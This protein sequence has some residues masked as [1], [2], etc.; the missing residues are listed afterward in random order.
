MI[1]GRLLFSFILLM[2]TLCAQASAFHWLTTGPFRNQ[3]QEFAFAHMMV[4]PS[5]N[6]WEAGTIQISLSRNLQPDFELSQVANEFEQAYRD[7]TWKKWQSKHAYYLQAEIQKENRIALIKLVKIQNNKLLMISSLIRPIFWQEAKMQVLHLASTLENEFVGKESANVEHW[8]HKVSETLIPQAQAQNFPN[9]PG[10]P[11]GSLP[12]LGPLMDGL[13]QMNNQI[14]DFN[15]SLSDINNNWSETNKIM[16]A[17]LSK[18]FDTK[19]MAMHGAVVGAATAAGAALG[20]WLAHQAING[21]VAII[22][23]LIDAID[24]RQLYWED[25]K[26]AREHYLKHKVAMIDV[27]R[28]LDATLNLLAKSQDLN[29]SE[30]LL[31][32]NKE[33]AFFQVIKNKLEQHTQVSMD[34]S[35]VSCAVLFQEAINLAESEIVNLGLAIDFYSQDKSTRKSRDHFF[36]QMLSDMITQIN[37]FNYDMNSFRVDI[38]TGA[39]EWMRHAKKEHRRIAQKLRQVNRGHNQKRIEDIGNRLVSIIQTEVLRAEREDRRTF[40]SRCRSGQGPIGSAIALKAK[41]E[42]KGV[43][44]IGR[45]CRDAYSLY[46]DLVLNEKRSAINVQVAEASMSLQHNNRYD[47]ALPLRLDHA[48]ELRMIS[49]MSD[50]F[51]DVRQEMQCASNYYDPNIFEGCMKNYPEIMGPIAGLLKAENMMRERGC[52]NRY[53]EAAQMINGSY[54]LEQVAQ[55]FR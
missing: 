41:G 25:F 48:S 2:A 43:I 40:M 17:A 30:V 49:Q 38:L 26:N 11:G 24:K 8:F 5:E 18:A 36:C 12:G 47:E 44:Y 4:G 37:R 27:E 32:L 42:N 34:K 52:A 6:A 31:L 21:A 1:L 13:N 45:Q 20:G 23:K 54:T 35:D 50:W 14:S 7:V 33:K 15:D 19:F 3:Q 10:L 46:A 55:Q 39:K 16:D 9:I 22:K 51:E 53:Y 28:K 29:P